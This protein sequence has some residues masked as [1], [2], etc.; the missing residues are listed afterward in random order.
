MALQRQGAC[1]TAECL[2]EAVSASRLRRRRRRR[3]RRQRERRTGG[4]ERQWAAGGAS[5]DNL[6]TAVH[7]PAERART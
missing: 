4:G 3:R 1:V 6:A 2:L 5:S 7:A